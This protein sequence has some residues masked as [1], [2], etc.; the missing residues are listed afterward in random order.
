MIHDIGHC[1]RKRCK[2]KGICK[3]HPVHKEIQ[4]LEIKDQI[5]D[6]VICKN[7]SL[8]WDIKE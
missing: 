7:R 2:I 1:N 3:R 8:F 4:D 6:Y 5:L